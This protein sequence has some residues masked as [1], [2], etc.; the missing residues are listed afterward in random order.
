MILGFHPQWRQWGLVIAVVA[1]ALLSGCAQTA[2][3]SP[4][5]ASPDRPTASDE[6]QDGR[7]ARVRLQL[8]SAYYGRGQLTTALDEVKLAIQADPTI[9]A[10][11]NLRGLI[12]AGLGDDQLAEESFRRALQMDGRDADAMHN[13][14]WYLCQRKRFD[15]ANA[16]F[17]RAL[18]IPQYRDLP[19]TLLAQGVCQARAG[20]LQAAEATL[21]RAYEIDAGNPAAA[22]NLSEVLYQRGEYERA[23]FFVRRVNAQPDVSS[24]QTLWLAA[25]IE[26][27]LGNA[28]GVQ[29]LGNQLRDRFPQSTEALAFERGK[30]H[31]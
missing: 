24:A 10:A 1:V 6:T 27:K 25:R 26:K 18:A 30:F 8:A 3:G 14:G 20:Q 22:V 9:A 23:R 29:A 13:F 12:Y 16:L 7:R 2:D 19:R 11:F 21:L 15:E 5:G 28:Q 31:E 4:S 17:L